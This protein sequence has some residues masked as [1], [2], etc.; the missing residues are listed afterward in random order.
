MWMFNVTSRWWTWLSG[1]NTTKQMGIYG[2][3]GVADKKN[4]PGAR[5]GHSMVM[6]PSGELMFVFGGWGYDTTDQGQ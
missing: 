2:T 6:H 5:D 1:S 3:Q 4:G